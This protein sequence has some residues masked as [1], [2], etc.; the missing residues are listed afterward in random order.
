MKRRKLINLAAAT[1]LVLLIPTSI[2]FAERE[3]PPPNPG[4]GDGQ[5]LILARTVLW[6]LP[7][8]T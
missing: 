3:D 7:H 5:G 4:V 6:L 8:E 1:L 2:A